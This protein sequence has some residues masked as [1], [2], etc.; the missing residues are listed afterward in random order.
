MSLRGV[1]ER[2]RWRFDAFLGC[3]FQRS[4][5]RQLDLARC[6]LTGGSVRHDPGPFNDLGD[7]ALVAFFRRIPN[8]DFIISGI[9]WH[10]CFSS[11][12]EIQ[13]LQLFPHLAH[14]I[15]LGFSAGAWLQ[16]QK[17]RSALKYYMAA[18]RFPCGVPELHKQRAEI[19][20]GKIRVVSTSR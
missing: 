10:R 12:F 7:E 9:R 14:L 18:F 3:D 1:R 19:I 11:W 4:L 8:A 13:F 5:E 15:H 6:F 17:T 20:E 16:V 2:R